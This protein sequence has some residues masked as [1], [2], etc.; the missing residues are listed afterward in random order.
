MDAKDKETSGG[1]RIPALIHGSSTSLTID[2]WIEMVMG[3]NT[4]WLW[5]NS[6]SWGATGL[7]NILGMCK[8]NSSSQKTEEPAGNWGILKCK[9]HF[10]GATRK[11]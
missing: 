1:V 3:L 7:I 8:K 4:L 11:F 10:Q 6:W 2:I 9:E 5:Q